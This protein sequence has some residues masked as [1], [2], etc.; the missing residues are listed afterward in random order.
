MPEPDLTPVREFK[1]RAAAPARSAV[2]TGQ[3]G[4]WRRWRARLLCDPGPRRSGLARLLID[5][6]NPLLLVLLPRQ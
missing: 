6:L 2:T 3:P 5:E 1:R 4:R